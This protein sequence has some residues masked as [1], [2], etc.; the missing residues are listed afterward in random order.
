MN[1][2]HYSMMY[3]SCCSYLYYAI[4]Y[5]YVRNSEFAKC[6]MRI[7]ELYNITYI[8]V[9]KATIKMIILFLKTENV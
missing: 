3:L 1:Y 5:R 6:I 7:F 9:Q 2:N 4:F 8:I